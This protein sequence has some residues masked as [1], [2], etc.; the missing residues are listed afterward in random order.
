MLRY[1]NIQERG[2]SL[3]QVGPRGED[4]ADLLDLEN[5]SSYINLP[6]PKE[7]E[8]SLRLSNGAP[9]GSKMSIYIFRGGS[10]AR[11]GVRVA[12]DRPGPLLLT[13]FSNAAAKLGLREGHFYNFSKRSSP[14]QEYCNICV[15]ELSN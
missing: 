4:E 10:I 7:R 8:S 3:A 12:V 6:W 1:D 9:C 13:E 15:R 14:R 11:I 2:S 5:R